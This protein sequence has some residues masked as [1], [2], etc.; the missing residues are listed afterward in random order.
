MTPFPEKREQR[1]KEEKKVFPLSPIAPSSVE[2]GEGKVK[3]KRK[4]KRG[5]IERQQ[6]YF[7]GKGGKGNPKKYQ[8]YR[9]KRVLFSS[10]LKMQA[11]L[12]LQ[13]VH[14]FIFTAT[15]LA[16]RKKFRIYAQYS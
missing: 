15:H 6:R 1:G 3:R 7:A 16:G 8:K 9:E 11:S 13:V 12:F 5:E 4:Y 10:Q 14:H 2:A